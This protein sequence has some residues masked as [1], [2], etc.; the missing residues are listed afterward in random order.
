MPYA[1]GWSKGS[2]LHGLNYVNIAKCVFACYGEECIV[3]PLIIHGM[4]IELH[5]C[6]LGQLVVRM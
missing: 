1:A 5:K 4:I 2:W 3:Y 6:V